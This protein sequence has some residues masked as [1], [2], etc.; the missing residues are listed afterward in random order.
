MVQEYYHLNGPHQGPRRQNGPPHH[1]PQGPPGGHPQGHPQGQPIIPPAPP[2]NIIPVDLRGGPAVQISDITQDIFTESDMKAE[3]TDYMVFRFEKMAEKDGLDDHGLPKWPSWEKAIR[4]EDR[5]ISKQAAADKIRELNLTTRGVIDKKNSLTSPQKRQLDQTL[6]YLMKRE[7]EIANFHWT[8]AQIDH[9]LRQ[10]K[11]YYPSGLNHQ[12]VSARKHRSSTAYPFLSTRSYSRSS[13]HRHHHHHSKK[14]KAY[15]RVALTAYFKRTPRQG[16]DI[17]RLWDQRRRGLEGMYQ[18]HLFPQ[19][20]PNHAQFPGPQQHQQQPQQ[21]HGGREPG[22]PPARMPNKNQQGPHMPPPRRPMDH[23]ARQNNGGHG[24]GH[25]RARRSDSD[26][27]SEDDSRDSSSAGSRRGSQSPP[28]SVSDHR[29]GGQHR[30][31][32]NNNNNKDRHHYPA[33]GGGAANPVRPH[34][35]R[36]ND[37]PGNAGHRPNGSPRLPPRPPAPPYPVSSREG[38]SVASHI[39]RVREDAYFRGR[40]A[41]RTDARLAEELA[42]SKAHGR[43][44][45]HIVQ[46]RSPGPR[47]RIYTRGRRGSAG[48]DDDDMLP[49]YFSRL[50]LWDDGDDNNNSEDEES[51]ELRR[52][53]ERRVQHGSI[54]EGFDPFELHPPSLSSSSYTYSTD[55][56]RGRR[57]PSIIEIPGRRYPISSPR[58]RRR[59]S[60]HP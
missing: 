58:L 12:Y 15:E 8:L 41:E 39:E 55:G 30:H 54:L 48:D 50:S 9:Q 21:H 27:D 17:F 25:N 10:I 22:P 13:S 28:T 4:T 49:R 1:P 44:R 18:A 45:P 23:N 43:P 33:G 34:T 6:D 38:G 56:V 19:M 16:V 3:L 36:K 2:R 59:M 51:L 47:T 7:P 52:E 24:H 37:R 57:R 32:N 14:K 40:L 46:A 20:Q 31:H 53:Y 60:Y 5:S 29:G 26:T 42:F 35:P 11:P